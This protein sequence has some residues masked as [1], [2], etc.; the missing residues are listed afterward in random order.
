MGERL[1]EAQRKALSRIYESATGASWVRF[2]TGEAL[3]KRG[4]V[5][6]ETCC[7]T[8]YV[9]ANAD[10]EHVQPHISPE[11]PWMRHEWYVTPAGRSILKEN[12][13]G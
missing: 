12:P 5:T 11:K 7:I 4:F 13:N 2:Q 9:Y 3:R 10:G 1:T 6:R 8:G